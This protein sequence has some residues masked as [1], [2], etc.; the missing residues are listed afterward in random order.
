[1]VENVHDTSQYGYLI[2]RAKQ[3]LSDTLGRSIQLGDTEVLSDADRRNTLLR[4]RNLSGEAPATF[5]IKQVVAEKWNPN[6]M[7]SWHTQR[8][9]K[10]WAGARFMSDLGIEP[11]CSPRYFCGDRDLGFFVMED[12]GTPR[13]LVDPLLNET[14]ADAEAALIAFSAVLGR[15]HSA[16]AGKAELY[17][18]IHNELSLNNS[19]V[20]TGEKVDLEKFVS[21]LAQLDVD[22]SAELLVELEQARAA[23]ESPG[24]YL[25]FIH[26]DPCPDNVFIVDGNAI[27]IDFEFA[28]LGHALIDAAYGRMMFPTCW[29][30]NR[31]PESTVNR[32]ETVYR[33]ELAKSVPE[34]ADDQKFG[35][36]LVDA[37]AYW[38]I[39]ALSWHLE[40][41]LTEDQEWGIST[42]RSRILSR[43]Q[44]FASTSEEFGRYVALRDTLILVHDKLKQRWPETEA[45]PLY[46]AFRN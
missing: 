21:Q 26:G 16:S 25:A 40:S 42:V 11:A 35:T 38:A 31:P 17:R 39:G 18:K 2:K 36:A 3:L 20:R 30:C 45:L 14:A 33:A 41:S 4:C 1:L 32:M 22:R 19:V 23:I 8:F 15:L 27:L 24:P 12:L 7:E 46:P 10:D 6:D 29:C 5:I 9:F 37:C 43:L 34:A 13:T 28:R 44:A